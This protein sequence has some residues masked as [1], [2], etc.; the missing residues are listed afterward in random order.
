VYRSTLAE[1]GAG[2]PTGTALE[3][4][5]DRYAE[6][7]TDL[8]QAVTDANEGWR[9]DEEMLAG[10]FAAHADARGFVLLG[11]P[12]ARLPSTVRA[13]DPVATRSAPIVIRVPAAGP[14]NPPRPLPRNRPPCLRPGRI[15]SRSRPAS[16]TTL[17]GLPTIR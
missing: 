5:G 3:Y 11:D 17:L 16:P 10:L 9:A 1:L 13:A 2:Q 14:A 12:A 7:A 6:L 4:V 15:R 8:N